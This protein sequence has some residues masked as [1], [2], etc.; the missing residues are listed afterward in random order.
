MRRAHARPA[1]Q[2][3]NLRDT[4]VR[5]WTPATAGSAPDRDGFY[6]GSAKTPTLESPTTLVD[7]GLLALVRSR[8]RTRRRRRHFGSSTISRGIAA[9]P[10][11]GAT[12]ARTRSSP[13]P[14]PKVFA[15]RARPDR[16][17][18]GTPPLPP[19]IV[20]AR[21]LAAG[22]EGTPRLDR[23]GLGSRCGCR[24]PPRTRCRAARRHGSVGARRG[25]RGRHELSTAEGTWN[26][27]ICPGRI[28]R[29]RSWRRSCLKATARAAAG[30]AAGHR[31]PCSAS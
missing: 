20:L 22:E 9:A 21:A 4:D 7:D 15:R 13:A 6:L 2:T 31:A 11:A 1:P 19:A 24:A 5:R 8:R 29:A 12:G 3:R 10:S 30:R 14:R 28:R 18:A 16:D 26:S 23:L 27:R 17:G 25:R